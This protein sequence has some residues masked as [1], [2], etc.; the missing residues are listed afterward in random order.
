MTTDFTPTPAQI[1]AIVL[2]GQPLPRHSGQRAET[3]RREHRGAVT[4]PGDRAGE[5]TSPTL[6][7][8]THLNLDSL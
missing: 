7:Y 4:L 8:E 3:Q 5:T 2:T 1:I 6:K